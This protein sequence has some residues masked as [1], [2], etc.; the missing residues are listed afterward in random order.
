MMRTVTSNS[1]IV[2][3]YGAVTNV[4]DCRLIRCAHKSFA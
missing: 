2:I 1:G 4:S 3:I